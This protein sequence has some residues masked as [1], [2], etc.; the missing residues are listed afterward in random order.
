MAD[1]Q[2]LSSGDFKCLKDCK[3][4]RRIIKTL[5]GKTTKRTLSNKIY[6]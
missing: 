1:K 3:N 2:E 6:T 4:S 5:E